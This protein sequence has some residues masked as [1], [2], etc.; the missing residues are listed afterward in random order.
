MPNL[1]IDRRKNY[2]RN[3]SGKGTAGR[4]PAGWKRP[5][6]RCRSLGK[7]GAPADGEWRLQSPLLHCHGQAGGRQPR[8]A[9]RGA[10]KLTPWG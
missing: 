6:C 3:A 2:P 4:R 7:R 10:G 8:P 5:A 9:G 1:D